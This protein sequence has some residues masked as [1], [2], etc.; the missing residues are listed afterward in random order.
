MIGPHFV[1]PSYLTGF[2]LVQTSSYFI[3]VCTEIQMNIHSSGRYICLL[4]PFSFYSLS[5]SFFV[6][7]LLLNCF[8]LMPHL[9][10]HRHSVH[11]N[12]FYPNL[13]SHFCTNGYDLINRISLFPFFLLASVFP[14]LDSITFL[15]NKKKLKKKGEKERKWREKKTN[16]RNCVTISYLP[17]YFIY[18]ES[19]KQRKKP[20]KSC[21]SIKFRSTHIHGVRVALKVV[22]KK[23]YPPSVCVCENCVINDVVDWVWWDCVLTFIC[24]YITSEDL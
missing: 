4:P 8:Q 15:F 21:E 24:T 16:K 20:K 23:N 10:F 17:P 6:L 19:W 14:S 7:L 22:D 18:F 9:L 5:S 12:R 13:P 1:L 11:T 2:K 3:W